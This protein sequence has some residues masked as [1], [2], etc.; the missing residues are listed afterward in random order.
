MDHCNRVRQVLI[1]MSRVY[2]LWSSVQH[3][4]ATSLLVRTDWSISNV[5]LTGLQGLGFEGLYPEH[6]ASG[7]CADWYIHLPNALAFDKQQRHMHAQMHLH[8]SAAALCCHREP[9][10]CG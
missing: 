7:Y 3:S 1:F 6:I 4:P 8:T 9:K 5:H 10:A 2:G